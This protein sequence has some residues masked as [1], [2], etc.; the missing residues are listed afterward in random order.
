MDAIGQD[1]PTVLAAAQ[2]GAE[3]AWTRLYHSLAD[4]LAGYAKVKGA[5]APDD[6]VGEVFHDIARNIKGFEGTE[7]N[8]RSWAFGI[9]HHRLIDQWRKAGRDREAG[10]LPA[11]ESARSAESMAL[12]ALPDGP[13]FAALAGLTET[14]RSVVILRTVADLSLEEVAEALDM[15]VNAV[16]AMQHRAFKQLRK[17]LQEPVTK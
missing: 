17:N 15:K 5:P 4:Q 2:E 3:W 1:F 16:K 11:A 8:F 13:A 7:S 9:A 12:A 6:V 14:Q 10:G